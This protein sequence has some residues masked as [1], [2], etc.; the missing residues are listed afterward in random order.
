MQTE[1]LKSGDGS[2]NNDSVC[3]FLFC[4]VFYLLPGLPSP[5]SSV[6]TTLIITATTHR[7]KEN[8]RTSSSLFPPP[9]RPSLSFSLSLSLFFLF[10]CRLL[11]LCAETPCLGSAAR[12]P[13]GRVRLKRGGA[14]CQPSCKP[15]RS[16]RSPPGVS[17][18][19]SPCLLNR[20]ARGHH[21][22]GPEIAQLEI[23]LPPFITG[24]GQKKSW[25][26]Q[27]SE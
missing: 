15:T 13:G 2:S 6:A 11:A 19:M 24:M 23:D 7:S 1:G 12:Q 21:R 8:S 5:S 4:C 25:D 26:L 14:K 18:P 10:F 3:H 16:K 17:S 20:E 22:R 9:P 27:V